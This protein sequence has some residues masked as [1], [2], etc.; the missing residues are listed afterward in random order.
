MSTQTDWRTLVSRIIKSEMAKKNLRY[1]DIANKLQEYGTVQT[2]GNL[3]NKINRGIMG[4]D[5]FIQIMLA[6]DMEAIEQKT[7]LEIRQ[8]IDNERKS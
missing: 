7:L 5:L 6:L 8:H 1:E 3:R 4:A 2:Q